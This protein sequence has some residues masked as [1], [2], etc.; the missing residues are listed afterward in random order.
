MAGIQAGS[1]GRLSIEIVAEIAR[2]QQDMDRAKRAVKA[3]SNDI[4]ASARA[5][6]DNLAGLSSGF[7]RLGEQAVLAGK[8]LGGLGV[9]LSLREIGRMADDWSDMNSRLA[10]ATGSID[11]GTAAMDRLVDVARRSYS[12]ISQTTEAFLQQ[13]TA[14]NALG[15]SVDRQLDLTEALNNSLVISATRG[16]RAQQ[17][18]DAWAKAMALGKMEGDQLNSI[19]SGSSRLALALADSLGGNVNQLRQFGKEGKITREVML[20]ITKQLEQLR[21]EADEMPATLSDGITLLKDGLLQ[22]VGRMDQ[23]LGPTGTLAQLM[24]VLADNLDLV[25]VAAAAVGVSFAAWKLGAMTAATASHIGQLIALEKALGATNVATALFG[26]ATKQVTT[27]FR[28]LTVVMMANPFMLVAGAIAGVTALL[29]ANRD[30]QIQVGDQTVRLGDIFLG[31]WEMVK[32]A[33]EFVQTLF[34]QGWEAAFGKVSPALQAIGALFDRVFNW[35]VT[36]IRDRVNTVIGIFTGLVASVNALFSGGSAIDAFKGAMGQDYVGA[37]GKAAADGIVALADMGR[38]AREAGTAAGGAAGD[39]DKFSDATKEAGKA[40]KAAKDPTKEFRDYLAGLRDELSKVGK[41]EAE[42]KAMEVA[43]KA[44]GAEKIGLKKVAAEIREVAAALAEAKA[45]QVSRDFIKALEDEASQIGKTTVELHRME[46]ALQAAAAPTDDLAQKIRDASAAWE[47]AYSG[48]IRKQIREQRA[49][50]KKEADLTRELGERRIA[51]LKGLHGRPLEEELAAINA[52]RD[53]ARVRLDSEREAAEWLRLGFADLAQEIRDTAAAELELIDLESKFDAEARAANYLAQQIDALAG[54]LGGLGGVSGKIGNV[55][56]A[57]SSTNPKS[58]LLNM[59]GIGGALGGLLAPGAITGF[60]LQL[61]G[62]LNQLG[63][64]SLLGGNITSLLGQALAGAGFG[65]AIGGSIG[66]LIGSSS[67]GQIGG[68]I[69]GGAFG[70]VG[71]IAGSIL[72]G[73]IGGLVKSTPRASATISVIAGEAMD[74]VVTGNKKKLREVAAGLGDGVMGS[75]MQIADA[76]GAELG[77]AS[78]SIGMRGKNF[79]VDTTGQG[80][81]KTKKGAVDFGK[82]E[83]AAIAFAIQDAI[84]DG[85][86]LGLSE[87]VERLLKGGGDLETQLQKALSFQSVFDELRQ[88]LDPEGFD[89]DQLDKW[90]AGMDKLFAEAGATAEELAKLEELTGLKR[91]EIVEKYANEIAQAED[92]ARQIRQLEIEIMRLTG[93]TLGALAAERALEQEGM[94]A[95]VVELMKRRDALVDEA[96]ATQEATRAAEEAAALQR[97]VADER[98]S[99][100][101]RLIPLLGDTAEATALMAAQLGRERDALDESNLA[102]FDRVK[103]LEAEAVAAAAAARAAEE[104][105]A[106]NKAIADEMSGL[107]RQWLQLIGDMD[108]LRSLQLGDLLSDG[109]REK[110]QMIWAEQDRQ[111]AEEAARRAAEEAARAAEQA[112]QAY[113]RAVEEHNRAVVDARNTLAQA[114]EREAGALQQT[115]DK[116][117]AFGKEIREFR[118]GLLGTVNPAVG[119]DQARAQFLSTSRMASLG[120]ESSL[121]RFTGDAQAFLD[122]ARG[123]AGSMVEYQRELAMVEREAMKAERGAGGMVTEAQRQL[124]A[125]EAQVKGILDLNEKVTTVREALDAYMAVQAR[126]VPVFVDAVSGGIEIVADRIEQADARQERREADAAKREADA[127]LRTEMML[128]ALNRIER[129]LS[130]AARDGGSFA[131]TMDGETIPVSGDVRITNA[132]GEPVPTKEVA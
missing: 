96:A 53:K 41:T 88:R 126:Q 85:V 47:A 19:I 72:G 84:S 73:V 44:L 117:R 5:A 65:G 124:R 82:D 60:G 3:A 115:I 87:G 15:V 56:G 113:A 116:F 32:K 37:I 29:Y 6:N 12:P 7:S 27:S 90:R 49:D 100:E 69:G 67:G 83:A 105:A 63:I 103:A 121:Q 66:G 68:A 125:L 50:I 101:S 64:G 120:N 58:A 131:V 109:A 76:F 108:T 122:L 92:D 102:L 98:Y 71:A 129:R 31:I 62:G 59:G 54:S 78:V 112:A 104:L 81:T 127:V 45:A 51:A 86:F 74:S 107:D 89:L 16:Q 34:S 97:A 132:T 40:A 95:A 130:Q 11:N 1:A 35:I 119:Y 8:A 106:R 14:L 57:I 33:T 38:Q 23:T 18:M 30:S 75:I 36:T 110:Q 79:R 43:L 94:S 10:N 4:A 48:D 22:L 93:D 21:T 99:L 39:V 9:A 52:E 123:R 13:S 114:Y 91:A 2:L 80:I 24:V 26:V 20:G 61:E 46:V 118:E 28:A 55:L 111:A 17:V 128:I 70:P 25:A 77:Q 42:I